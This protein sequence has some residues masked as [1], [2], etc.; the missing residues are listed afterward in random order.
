FEDVEC[1]RRAGAQWVGMCV[2][3]QGD[4]MLER[5]DTPAHDCEAVQRVVEFAG[6]AGL[7]VRF[8]V[9]GAG[10][11][12]LETVKQLFSAAIGAGADR[13]CFADTAGNLRPWETEEVISRLCE[14]FAGREMEV[15]FHD[16]CG[17]A[18]ANALVAARSG[19]GWVSCSVNGIGRR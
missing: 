5:T 16:D 15:Q 17:M 8:T 7:S 12:D 4:D 3:L 13:I 1:V 2:G 11:G 19:A 18:E 6:A 9:E 14:V 10:A